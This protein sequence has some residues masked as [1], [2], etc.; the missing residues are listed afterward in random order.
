ML[1]FGTC[2]PHGVYF[3]YE[4]AEMNYNLFCQKFLSGQNILRVWKFLKFRPWLGICSHFLVV[5][6]VLKLGELFI[7]IARVFCVKK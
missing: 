6:M 1:L 3:E 7:F 2:K 4:N 5:R